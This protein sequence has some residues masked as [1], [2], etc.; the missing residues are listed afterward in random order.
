MGNVISGGGSEDTSS[1]LYKAV[2]AASIGLG[3]AGAAVGEPLRRGAENYLGNVGKAFH[4]S[5]EYA[6]QGL[7]NTV[8]DKGPLYNTSGP[9]QYALGSM[10]QAF[11]PLTGAAM[12]AGQ[13]ATQLT[14]NPDFGNRV[15]FVGGMMDPSHVGM[16]K[17]AAAIP[18][19]AR[20]AAKAEEAAQAVALA[21]QQRELS[22]LGFYSHGA[23]TAAGLQQAKGTPQQYYSM[24]EKSGVKPA[25][26]EGF[27]EAFAGRPSVTRE[28][29]A[30][31]FKERMPQ[32]EETVLRDRKFKD[33]N[34]MQAAHDAALE[35]GDTAAANRITQDWEAQFQ[36]NTKFGQY[37]LPG[38]ENYREVR[39]TLP[40][41]YGAP[42]QV[43]DDLAA[44]K[45]RA[46]AA[47]KAYTDALMAEL[48]GTSKLSPE[49]FAALE[50]ENS[51]ASSRV[52]NF[53]KLAK[54][55]AF[56]SSHWP[57]APNTVA[58]LRMADRTG[59]NGEKILHVEE[60]QSDW[61]QKGKKEGFK[62]PKGLDPDLD[63]WANS[64]S[65]LSPEQ[66]DSLIERLRKRYNVADANEE[67]NIY[68]NAI[69]QQT[70]GIPHAPYVTNTQ[71][72][73][74][75]ALKRALREAAEGGYDKLVW[76]PGAEQAKRYD[77]SK[78]VGKIYYDPELAGGTL[79]AE[80]L[81]PGQ[82]I[83]D[84]PNIK[85]E[86]IADYIG[87]EAAEKLL[88]QPRDPNGMH[89]LEGNGLS[90]G[91]EGMK[92]YY[93]KIVPNQLSKLVKKLDPEAKV[94]AEKIA[95]SRG[96]T[97]IIESDLAKSLGVSVED[98]RAMTNEQRKQAIQSVYS[99]QLPSLTITPKMREAIMKGQTAFKRGGTIPFGPDA[100]QRAVQIAKQQAG[101]R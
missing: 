47:S 60:I 84:K 13:A 39:L 54:Q 5:G 45:E 81:R 8:S 94:G 66:Y 25:E 22:P 15:E 42:Q 68:A 78:Q 50:K 61:G 34:E 48:D 71:A 56:Q 32:I 41:G 23:E 10:G 70:S 89:I 93:D 75:L 65:K 26:L 67:N 36:G 74:D 40:E 73:T 14:G 99:A 43:L 19:A 57:D 87:K 1:P 97:A 46:S 55:P 69:D 2:E 72:W 88:S 21:K 33:V 100:A 98:I 92:G 27:N 16:L 64:A 35:R 62:S 6:K 82:T 17:G 96:N 9:L 51:I 77:L 95:V 52:K 28:E 30:A 3:K 83:L 79:A 90:M 37:T 44:A 49:A 80:G 7:E 59:P 101:R 4:E 53:E 58:H 12:S 85:P 63:V 86:N 20:T 38:G 24:L 76:T 11:S 31:H 91:G 29:I 18:M